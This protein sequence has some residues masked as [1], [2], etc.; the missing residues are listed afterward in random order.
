MLYAVIAKDKDGGFELRKATRD[1]HLVFLKGL[2]D[3]VKVGGPFLNT[4]AQ[5]MDG[6]LL[7]IEAGSQAEAEAMMA[8]D[9]YAKAGLFTSVEIRPWKW[10]V[11][12]PAE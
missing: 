11:N 4:E 3:K 5:T 9:P 2:G 12:A 10:T 7:I 6:S 1:T 8:E